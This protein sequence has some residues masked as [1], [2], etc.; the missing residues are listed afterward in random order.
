LNYGK[1]YKYSHDFD[2]HFTDQQYLPDE[3]KDKIYYLPTDI[4]G[5]KKLK[6]RLEKLW[7]KRKKN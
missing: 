1:D 7:K 3:L 6:D 5:E 4:G 2:E